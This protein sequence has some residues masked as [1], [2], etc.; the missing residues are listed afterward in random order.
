MVTWENYEEYM[1]LQ[2]DGELSEEAQK[3]LLEFMQLHPELQD[4]F[5]K[6]QAIT[7]VPDTTLVYEGK[8]ALLKPEPAGK[9]I[10][11][12]QWRMYG[13]AAGVILIVLLFS[14]RW[15]RSGNKQSVN[16]TEIA[17]RQPVQPEKPATAQQPL[18]Q[19]PIKETPVTRPEEST[20]IA[21]R[22]VHSNTKGLVKESAS[23][24]RTEL[25]AIHPVRHELEVARREHLSVRLISPEVVQEAQPEVISTERKDSDFLAWLPV[26]SEKKEGLRGLKENISEKLEHAKKL[27]ETIK[28]TALAL[29]IGNKEITINF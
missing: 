25:E 6:F 23:S 3:A 1:I 20:S 9:I 22:G 28:E 10:S 21:R 8:A 12:G 18:K 17:G 16:N 15:I 24:L 4:E 27:P 14:S 29:K 5:K 11:L 13:A 7:L 26:D 19:Q 2:I